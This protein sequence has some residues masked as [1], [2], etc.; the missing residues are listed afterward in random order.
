M[1]EYE[2]KETT[3]S[4]QITTTI[5]IESTLKKEAS[6]LFES[7]GLDMTTA[8]NMF[9]RQAVREQAIPFRVGEP[10]LSDRALA[11]IKEVRDMED[12]PERY[13]SYTD[14]DEMMKELM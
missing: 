10:K 2:H 9:L 11:A 8:I 5:R 4:N 12:H 14:V 7:L 13:K 3:M 6:A 1:L